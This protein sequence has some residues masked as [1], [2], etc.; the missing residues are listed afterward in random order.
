MFHI[1][2]FIGTIW[3]LITYSFLLTFNAVP[4]KASNSLGMYGKAKRH[5][6]RSWYWFLGIVFLGT[7]IAAVY[8][9]Y[10]LLSIWARDYFF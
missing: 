6:H 4:E 1:P 2:S 8:F 9:T 3:A 5:L 7:T 10:S